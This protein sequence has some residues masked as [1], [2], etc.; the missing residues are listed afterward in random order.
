MLGFSRLGHRLLAGLFGLM[1]CATAAGAGDRVAL[2]I[3]NSNYA[4]VQYLPNAAR[5]ARDVAG[6]LRRIGFRVTLGIDLSQ[7]E[8]LEL[9]QDV[10]R[11][12][13]PDDIGLFYFSGHAVQIGSENLLIPVDAFGSD[14]QSIRSR[15]VS[16]Q[17][18]LYEMESKADRNVIILDACRNNPFEL[19]Q[20]ARSIGQNI[21]SGLARVD[22]GVG[23]FIA[24]STQPGNVASDGAGRN[25]PFTAALLRHL[26]SRDDDLHEVMRKVR[27]DVHVETD[28]VQIPWEN[29]SLIEKVFLA[30]RPDRPDRSAVPLTQSRPEPKPQSAFT[31]LVA[32]LDPDGDGFLALRAAATQFSPMLMQMTEGTRLQVLEQNGVWF[33]VR[34]VEG[35]IGWAHSNWIRFAG[36]ETA[37]GGSETCDSLWYQ[38]NLI[39][40]RKGYCFQSPR[41]QA[42]FSNEGCTEG[43]AAGDIPLTDAESAEVQR[44]VAR[45]RALGC[46]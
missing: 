20:V 7:A 12:L 24:F 6:A 14:V 13:K 34:T 2:V 41:G 40:D 36:I 42:A 22:A 21:V 1:I 5:D 35:R 33:N 17:T 32:G 46:R 25:S 43:L 4:H 19:S 45:E 38:R 44:L 37:A 27:R 9:T 26:P 11:S 18:I 8:I 16:L 30:A 31:Y 28:G 3:G 15:S 29:S 10:Q 39:Y 23:S